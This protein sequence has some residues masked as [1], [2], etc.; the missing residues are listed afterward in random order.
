MKYIAVELTIMK[1]AKNSTNMFPSFWANV[2]QK[3]A[4]NSLTMKKVYCSMFPSMGISRIIP[5]K[6]YFLT[7][8]E[9]L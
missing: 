4:L 1:N 6:Q 7:K 5:K 3:K 8:S 9:T 2:K